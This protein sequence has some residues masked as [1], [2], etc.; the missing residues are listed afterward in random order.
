VNNS[1]TV[2]DAEEAFWNLLT[3]FCTSDT[4]LGLAPTTNFG[5]WLAENR[6]V[7]SSSN[8]GFD[9]STTSEPTDS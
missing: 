3:T 2:A 9:V 7:N 8:D 4:F 6:E 1:D 5:E